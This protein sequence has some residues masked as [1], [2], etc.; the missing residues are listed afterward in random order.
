MSETKILQDRPPF[1]ELAIW[2]IVGAA[3]AF[4]LGM[5]IGEGRERDKIRERWMG[6]GYQELHPGPFVVKAYPTQDGGVWIW[7]EQE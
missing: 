4:L 7:V 6:H 1:W 3:L 5:G 2:V